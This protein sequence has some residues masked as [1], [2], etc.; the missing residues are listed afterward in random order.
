M[1][2]RFLL[3]FI[4]GFFLNFSALAEVKYAL[5]PENPRPG[6]PVTI[7]VNADIKHAVLFKN[8]RQLAKASFFPVGDFKAAVLTIPSTLSSGDAVI[9]L[10]DEESGVLHEIAFNVAARNFVSE[11]IELNPVLTGIRTDAST[12]RTDEANHLWAVLSHAGKDVY[13]TGE[14]I[15]PVN[16]TRRTSFFGD[17]RVFKYS[18]GNSDTSIHAGVDYG[19]PTGTGVVACGAGKVIIARSRIVTGNSIVIEHAPGIYSLYYHLSSIT[20]KEGAMVNAGTLIGLSG[21]TGL[22]TGPHLHW[23]LRIN[24]ENTDPDSFVARPII[25]KQ[26]IINRLNN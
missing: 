10:E 1:I 26:A 24:T 22:A 23:E 2:K 3:I 25:D 5:M 21:A 7:G 16:S 14:F 13:H 18:D 11:V 12:Q 17:R 4:A 9:R 6:E 20:V 15:P 8:E 19:V